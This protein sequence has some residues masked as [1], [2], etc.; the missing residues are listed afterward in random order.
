NATL[1]QPCVV[2]NTTY[3]DL[4]PD[5]AQYVTTIS[6]DNCRTPYFYCGATQGV[7]LR[8]LSLGSPCS[9]DRECE[10]QNCVAGLCTVSP[11]TP[12]QV[13]AW[14]CAITIISILGA[15]VAAC[16]LLILLHKRQ[17]FEQY[18]ELRDYYYEQMR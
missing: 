10:D 11:E 14:Q 9:V 8:S 15:M 13:P 18:Q 5:G 2:E 16:V 12:R 6:R 7:C 4:E 1:G 17:R 3:V